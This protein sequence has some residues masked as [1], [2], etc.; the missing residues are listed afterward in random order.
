MV[1]KPFSFDEDEIHYKDDIDSSEETFQQKRLLQK[2]HDKFFYK[3][4]YYFA[5]GSNLDVEQM[6]VRCPNSE[7]IGKVSLPNWRLVF[8]GVADIEPFTGS[9]VEGGIWKIS[10]SDEVALDNY[11]VYPSL[12]IKNYFACS[13]DTEVVEVMFYQMTHTYDGTQAPNRHY[14]DTILRGYHQFGL[15]QKYLV[16]ALMESYKTKTGRIHI[17][18]KYRKDR[19][20]NK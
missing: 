2:R 3:T 12:Y 4:P 14:Y 20:L 1:N 9:Q 7:M 8:R 15:E 19:K 17:Q 6:K 16:E 13:I 5:Y 11:E 18:K 10:E